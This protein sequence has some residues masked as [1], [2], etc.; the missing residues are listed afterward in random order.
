NQC[1][2]QWELINYHKPTDL[3]AGYEVKQSGTADAPSIIPNGASGNLHL[4][5]PGDWNKYDALTLAAYDP[6]KNLI[7]KWIWKIKDNTDLLNV[8]VKLKDTAT[9]HITETDS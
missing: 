7:Y 1:T 9:S 3:F 4:D 5:L 8:I 2:Y 6:F